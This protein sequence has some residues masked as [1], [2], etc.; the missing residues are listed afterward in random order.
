MFSDVSSALLGN[1]LSIAAY[2]ES[3]SLLGHCY[4]APFHSILKSS[5]VTGTGILR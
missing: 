5:K 1:I 3:Y 2:H 4:I